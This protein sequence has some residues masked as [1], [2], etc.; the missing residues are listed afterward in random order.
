MRWRN[1]FPSRSARRLSTIRPSAH[2]P[3]KS[4]YPP[5]LSTHVWS[6]FPLPGLDTD[7]LFPASPFP[8]A[9]RPSKVS[10]MTQ[11]PSSDRMTFVPAPPSQVR[12]HSPIQKSNWRA[13]GDAQGRAGSGAAV[14]R[15][16]L[17]GGGGGG[18]EQN[19]PSPQR[20]RMIFWLA[21]PDGVATL[22]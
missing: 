1:V 16:F 21:A 14:G 6:H 2:P 12:S 10:S 11:P 22:R 13:S 20:M 9:F 4:R 18:R 15:G 17:G 19:A 5:L 7:T 3:S 8:S